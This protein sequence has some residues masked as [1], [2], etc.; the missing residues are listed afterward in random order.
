[1]IK[2]YIRV[3]LR[4][5][6]RYKFF[7]FINIFGLAISMAV[8][9]AIIMLVADQMSYDQYN[10]K[11]GRLY[12]VNSQPLRLDGK[13]GN[14]NETSTAP[15][16][17]KTKLLDEYT[18]VE[19]AARILRGFGNNWLALE[20]GNVNIPL[21]GYYADPEI[22][23]M[24]EYELEY[25]DS[26]TALIEPNSVVLTKEAARKLFSQ[27]NPMGEFIKVGSIG[28]YKVTGILKET[29]NKTH[30]AFE[31]LASLSSINNQ[32]GGE[33]YNRSV[34]NWDNCWEGWVYL[35]L[36]EGRGAE[37]IETHLEAIAQQQYPKES[38]A[39]FSFSLLPI[40]SIT[41]GRMLN[42]PIGPSLPFVFIYFMGGLAA[43]IMITACFNYTNLSIARSL[44]RAKEI[45]VRKVSGASRWSIFGQFITESVVI[46]LFSLVLAIAFLSL[47]GPLMFEFKIA[48]ALKWDL[49]AD[50][51]VYLTFLVFSLF[52]GILA[53]LFPALVLSRFKP[54]NVLKNLNNMKLFSKIGLRKALLVGQFALS[55]IFILSVSLVYR[56][57]DLFVSADHGF[58]LENKINIRLNETS[59]DLLKTELLKHTNIQSVSASSHLPSTGM[60]YA[61]NF[62]KSLEEEEMEFAYFNVD[63]D[64][65]SNMDIEMVAGGNFPE[66]TP[67]N[68]R[69]YI[70]INEKA[71]KDLGYKSAL[72][73]IGE[74]LLRSDSSK[75]EIVGVVKDYNHDMMIQEIGAMALL[76]DQDRFNVL[77][78]QYHGDQ[79]EATKT[80][81]SAWAKINPTLKV[82][83]RVFEEE[84]RMMYD[85]IFGDITRFVGAITFLAICISCLGLLG[86]ATYT[87]ETR[88]KEI[89]IRK[90]LGASE[91]SLV[92]HL[93]KGFLSLIAIAIVIALPLAY[94]INNLWLQH[95]AYRVEMSLGLVIFGILVLLLLGLITIGSQTLK[96]AFVNPV[97][98][99]KNE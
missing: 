70:L 78:V 14:F 46:S 13:G 67:E 74:Q 2:N 86:M 42:N 28:D 92:Y 36:E 89:S 75:V 60:H 38:E 27:E 35:L 21:A 16:A 43:I 23:D 84:V 44:T 66:T 20:Q 69:N 82:D 54:V 65:I 15:L 18:G 45:G 97:D 91:R 73:A 40:R 4:N 95:M 58:S 8:C 5:L 22:L 30:I 81:E 7:S 51:T 56:Q 11:K 50:I 33:R 31:A 53:G 71:S 61:T 80:I 72:D 19:Q 63:E 6:S 25:G 85:L 17:I 83:H 39:A 76:Y 10:T 68:Q 49:R 57:L 96:A 24:M 87:T 77:Q 9:L 3:A 98:Q 37:E 34:T 64:Y 41:P 52:I 99:L 62:R 88:M 55:M 26:K 32:D 47:L 1:M 48:K 29:K 90:V 59:A 12:Q 93:S 79:T 94:F